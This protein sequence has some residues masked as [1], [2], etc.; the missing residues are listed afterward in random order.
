[1]NVPSASSCIQRATGC[2]ACMGTSPV[3]RAHASGLVI[4][5]HMRGDPQCIACVEAIGFEHAG[6]CLA[7]S[8]YRHD[9]N[10]GLTSKTD[11]GQVSYRW[12]CMHV[13]NGTALQIGSSYSRAVT[14]IQHNVP[15]LKSLP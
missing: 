13:L 8:A 9:V 2:L 10:S 14:S 5:D 12:P 3:C 1:M 6:S 11:G 4:F 7:A 15:A